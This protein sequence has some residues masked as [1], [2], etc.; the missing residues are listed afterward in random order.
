MQ[1]TLLGPC[2][3]YNIVTPIDMFGEIQQNWRR[4]YA[5]IQQ[6][7]LKWHGP[8]GKFKSCRWC[9]PSQCT[10]SKWH[11]CTLNLRTYRKL[12]ALSQINCTSNAPLIR[13]HVKLYLSWK[14]CVTL[15]DGLKHIAVPVIHNCCTAVATSIPRSDKNA[16]C[17]GR[18]SANYWE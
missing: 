13:I 1:S 16:C 11:H 2:S 15:K 10:M 14:I 17:S 6:D 8:T 7:Q 18:S 3:I 9:Q 12:F 5:Q 4:D